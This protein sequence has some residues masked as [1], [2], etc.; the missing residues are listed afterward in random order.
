MLVSDACF[1]LGRQPLPALTEILGAL[2]DVLDDRDVVINAAGS[3]P[4]DLQMLGVKLAA[5]DREV[6]VLVGDASYL[7]MAQELVT[8]V[9]EGLKVIVVV[10][11][12]HGFA[13]I[14]ALSES[15]GSQRFGTQGGPLALVSADFGPATERIFGAAREA[16]ASGL[17]TG[18][19]V[20]A[21]ASLAGA[22]ITLLV[23]KPDATRTVTGTEP[24]TALA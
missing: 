11:Q 22:L 24:A 23:I 20:C 6:V 3:L 7:M 4:G 2:H 14:G 10:V 8:M 9:S 17:T 5:P 15:L 18:L 13:S 19:I 1:S 12:N 21:V 16:L